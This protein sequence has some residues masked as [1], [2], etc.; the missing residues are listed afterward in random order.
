MLSRYD[1]FYLPL[2]IRTGANRG[3]AFLNLVDPQ[4]AQEFYRCFHGRKLSRSTAEDA[5]LAV[6]RADMQGFECNA[7]HYLS[8]G[9]WVEE[10]G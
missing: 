2:D 1:F 7:E 10:L 3:F 4:T 5:D 8:P 9:S 6:L